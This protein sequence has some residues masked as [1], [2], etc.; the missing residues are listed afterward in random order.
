MHVICDE[1]GGQ[2]PSS[3][4]KYRSGKIIYTNSA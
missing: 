3:S 1:Y 2:V 4:L